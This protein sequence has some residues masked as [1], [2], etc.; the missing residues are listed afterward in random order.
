[1]AY[2]HH[3]RFSSSRGDNFHKD[4]TAL[5][6][7]LYDYRA[8][9]VVSSHDHVYE[10][11]APRTPSGALDLARGIRQFTAGMG[12]ARLYGFGAISTHSEARNNDTHGVLKLVLED[13]AYTWE[14]IPVAGKSF[15][16][17]GRRNCH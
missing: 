4:V 17:S 15:T 5:W 16:D 14:F 6:Q 7:A 2:F 3:P 10:R 12:G 13:N 1:V 8:D 11:F 9:V